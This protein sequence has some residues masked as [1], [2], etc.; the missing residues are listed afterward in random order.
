M[1]AHAADRDK[2]LD[3]ARP[4]T[5]SL[6]G[7]INSEPG[8]AVDGVIVAMH[9]LL[10]WPWLRTSRGSRDNPASTPNRI[11]AATSLWAF[12]VAWTR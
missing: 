8:P 1:H 12:N 2:I 3:D 7:W 5:R 11:S 9:D 4:R 6:G 10:R